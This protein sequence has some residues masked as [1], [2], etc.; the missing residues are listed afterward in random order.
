MPTAALGRSHRPLP[1]SPADFEIAIICALPV[2]AEAVENSIDEFYDTVSFVKA[3]GD[4]NSYTLGRIGFH[5]VVLAYMPGMGKAT[6]ASVSA[7]F[8]SSFSGIEL[9]LVIG[10]CG[11]VPTNPENGTPIFLGDIIIS[12]A[13]VQFDFIRQYPDR[14]ARKDTLEDNLGRPSLGIRSYLAKLKTRRNRTRIE[15]DIIRHLSEISGRSDCEEYAYPGAEADVLYS[16]NFYH[17]HHYPTSCDICSGLQNPHGEVC[18]SAFDLSCTDLRCTEADELCQKRSK[19]EQKESDSGK[20]ED[21]LG[22]IKP[23]VHLGRVASGDVVMKSGAHRNHIAVE[24]KV[25]GFEMEGAGVW[26]NFPTVVIKG[27]CDYSDSHKSKEWQPYAAAAAASCMKA[28]LK[29]W[30]SEKGSA[31]M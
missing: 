18:S 30:R 21:L 13:V 28:F 19:R 31:C 2:E 14:A 7:S 10:I 1:Q 16:P 20:S 25:I 11:G 26:D 29:D 22:D 17:K 8:R 4:T 15:E 12:T 6:S 3:A 5:N 23:R 27:V 24:E 9:G